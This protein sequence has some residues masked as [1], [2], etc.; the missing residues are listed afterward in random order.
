MAG[1]E[2]RRHAGAMITLLAG[3]GLLVAV[4]FHLDFRPAAARALGPLLG[5][6]AL[7]L[8][9][10]TVIGPGRDRVVRGLQALVGL[11]GCFFLMLFHSPLVYWMSLPLLIPSRPE[12]ADAIVVF[13]AG[14]LPSGE[15]TTHSMQRALRGARLYREGYAPRLI[16]SAGNPGSSLPGITEAEAMQAVTTMAG[17]PADRTLVEKVSTR[18]AENAVEVARLMRARGYRSALLV[19]HATHMRRASA[20]LRR[21]GIVVHPAAVESPV[22][23]RRWWQGSAA[24]PV[25]SAVVHEYLGLAWYRLRGWI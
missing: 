11:L 25:F 5:L 17:V 8:F 4:L 15:A 6:I 12:R 10:R 14:V 3:F 20:A 7:G 23:V 19:T 16:L 13:G 24:F 21:Q 18:T 9:A 2:R 1:R 22:D